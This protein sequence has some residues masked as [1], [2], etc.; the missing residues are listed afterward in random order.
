MSGY[1]YLIV[2][3][4]GTVKGGKSANHKRRLVQH[5]GDAGKYGLK[6]KRYLVT[7]EHQ[8]YHDTEKRLL[9]HLRQYS[10]Y[11]RG[12]YFQDICEDNA[13]MVL[14]SLGHKVDDSKYDLPEE[15][16]DKLDN[17]TRMVRLMPHRQIAA[18]T[19]CKVIH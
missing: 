19:N 8:D 6:V 10:G 2:F 16:Q 18:L 4:N 13:V 3:T 11:Y 7:A 5:A 15:P 14:C 1:C 17:L 9:H 12:E